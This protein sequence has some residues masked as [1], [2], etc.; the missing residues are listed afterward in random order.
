MDLDPQ[1][2]TRGIGLSLPGLF[3]GAQN[4]LVLWLLSLAEAQPYSKIK[5]SQGPPGII[6]A[7]IP[8]RGAQGS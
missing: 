6:I 5:G 4:H 3:G 2:W 8:L 7:C 1:L